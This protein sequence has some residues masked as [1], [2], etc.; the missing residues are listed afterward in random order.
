MIDLLIETLEFKDDSKKQVSPVVKTYPIVSTKFP[1]G[2]SQVWK[3]PQEVIDDIPDAYSITID[4]RFKEERELFDLMSLWA[5]LTEELKRAFRNKSYVLN[6]E[7]NKPAIFIDDNAPMPIYLN[8]FYLPFARQDKLIDN[9]NT[10]NLHVFCVMLN[11]L[12]SLLRVPLLGAVY[13]PISIT[14]VR[15]FDPHSEQS[16]RAL[17]AD[18]DINKQVKVYSPSSSIAHG[19]QTF[20]EFANQAEKWD[21]IIF[22]DASASLKYPPTLPYFTVI[23]ERNCETGEIETC[24]LS[25]RNE[26]AAKQ[27]STF[28]N[29]LVVDDI[30]D[31]GATFI[32]CAEVLKSHNPNIEKLGLRVSHGIFSK[33]FE[34]LKAAGFTHIFYTDSLDPSFDKEI[35]EGLNVFKFKL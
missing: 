23:K 5:L 11:S 3:L 10:F 20:S 26:N 7:T 19:D 13:R 22:P 1:D 34:P 9:A 15:I 17:H 6:V 29:V 21:A 12:H 4:W 31:G 30:C 16:L 28:K 33:G 14:E 27:F 25:F 8:L 32:K 24:E 18:F 35:P 2:T